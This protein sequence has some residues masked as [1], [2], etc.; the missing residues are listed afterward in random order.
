[1]GMTPIERNAVLK[2]RA[3]T[4]FIPLFKAACPRASCDL[5]VVTSCPCA[6]ASAIFFDRYASFLAFTVAPLTEGPTGFGVFGGMPGTPGATRSA[7]TVGK[8][9]AG[10]STV[11]LPVPGSMV[12]PHAEGTASRSTPTLK[13]FVSFI[14]LIFSDTI[15]QQGLCLISAIVS[16]NSSRFSTTFH[17]KKYI[18]HG[19]DHLSRQVVRRFTESIFEGGKLGPG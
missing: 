9:A 5:A 10:A 3:A 14:S 16:L 6:F 7:G 17:C 13:N 11:D 4:S 12:W 2:C 1:M 19:A 8:T 15:T 18:V